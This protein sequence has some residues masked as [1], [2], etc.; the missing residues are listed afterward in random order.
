MS[1]LARWLVVAMTVA[2]AVSG[3]AAIALSWWIGPLVM[4]ERALEEGQLDVAEA[5]YSLA[6][7]RLAPLAQLGPFERLAEIAHTGR[8]LTAYRRGRYETVLEAAAAAPPSAEVQFWSG[9]AL[10]R[11]ADADT[12]PEARLDWLDQAQAAFRRA[13]ELDPQHWDAKVN[14]ELSRRVLAR[15]QQDPA[16]RPTQLMP[17]LRPQPRTAPPT[18]RRTG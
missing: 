12:A 2:A 17:L 14:Y 15:L 4:A 3:L 18:G 8:V 11:K 10:F 6:A 7:R 5:Q 9:C 1:H 16:L 13:L